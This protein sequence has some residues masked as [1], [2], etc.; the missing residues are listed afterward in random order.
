M[1]HTGD[2]N[3]QK[4]EAEPWSS[5]TIYVYQSVLKTQCLMSAGGQSSLAS[6]TETVSSTKVLFKKL[7]EQNKLQKNPGLFFFHPAILFCLSQHADAVKRVTKI[8]GFGGLGHL[9]S[10]L[11]RGSCCSHSL[12]HTHSATACWAV[13]KTLKMKR[14][15]SFRR[16]L[17]P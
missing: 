17:S 4:A 11:P 8:K 7:T 13:F 6:G 10:S 14:N 2:R 16:L 5:D 9:P 1:L 15:Y 3:I 12:H